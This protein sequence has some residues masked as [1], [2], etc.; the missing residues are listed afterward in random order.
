MKPCFAERGWGNPQHRCAKEM[1]HQEVPS[2]PSAK[3]SIF[4]GLSLS[5]GLG[6]VAAKSCYLLPLLLASSGLGGAWLSR[7]LSAF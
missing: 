5:T 4:A 7:E 6:A 2:A 1:Q 3:P